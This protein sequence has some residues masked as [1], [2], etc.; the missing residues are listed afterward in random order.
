MDWELS[1]EERI[2]DHKWWIS[3]MEEFRRDYPGWELSRGVED[4]LREI[5]DENVEQWAAAAQSD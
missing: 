2:G 3:D 4:L 1:E 5:H